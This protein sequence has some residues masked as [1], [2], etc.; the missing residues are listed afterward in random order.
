MKAHIY[1]VKYSL[2]PNTWVPFIVAIKWLYFRLG[3]VCFLL[4][5]IGLCLLLVVSFIGGVKITS[6]KLQSSST[7]LR[8]S[9]LSFRSLRWF[10]VLFMDASVT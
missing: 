6:I 5:L 4:C 9:Q 8:N 7:C 1:K 2:L 3:Y 10:D